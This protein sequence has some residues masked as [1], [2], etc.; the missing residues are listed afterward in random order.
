MN[1]KVRCTNVFFLFFGRGKRGGGG[2]EGR[3]VLGAVGRKGGR[4]GGR[5]V[6]RVRAPDAAVARGEEDRDAARSELG[7]RLAQL[8]VTPVQS[9]SASAQ[10]SPTHKPPHQ[11]KKQDTHSV[12]ANEMLASAKP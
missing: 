8:A 4:K 2:R 10:R 3:D 12:N 1:S 7:V 9:A 5:V 6:V 11:K